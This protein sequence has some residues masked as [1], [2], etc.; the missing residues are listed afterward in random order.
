[1]NIGSI[2]EFDD[3]KGRT[4]IGSLV[5]T[6]H[7]SNGGARFE[8]MGANGNTYHIGEKSVTFSTPP[9]ANPKECAKLLKDLN[10]AHGEDAVELRMALNVDAELIALAW[11]ETDSLMEYSGSQEWPLPH[12]DTITAGAFL[13]LVSG[14]PAN[15]PAEKYRAWRLLGFTELGH[16]FFKAIK[17]KGRV[18]SFRAKTAKAVED[19][20]KA[21]CNGS[22]GNEEPGFC[23]I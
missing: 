20:K 14:A 15:S 17:E 21:F 12:S 7:K 1:M 9:P 10:K 2:C 4:Y 11:E 13:E 22:H 16:I 3:G 8:M 18:T 23:L 5:A 6:E 19:A